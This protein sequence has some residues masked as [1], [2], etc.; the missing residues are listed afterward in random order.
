M[1]EQIVSFQPYPGVRPW[2]LL[3][4]YVTNGWQAGNELSS[5]NLMG[6]I[7]Y[8]EVHLKLRTRRGTNRS[9]T[10]QLPAA[11][12]PVA[13]QVLPISATGYPDMQVIIE[14]TGRIQLFSG[15]GAHNDAAD[16]SLLNAVMHCSY[17]R[18]G[19]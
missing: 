13:Q 12:C 2:V 9:I 17:L 8:N 6:K 18:S 10:E 4:E 11:F 15:S 7:D 16:G 19:T 3:S 5:F 14:T 1:S